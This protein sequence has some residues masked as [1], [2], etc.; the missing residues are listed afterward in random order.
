MDFKKRCLCTN[1]GNS[2]PSIRHKS[3]PIMDYRIFARNELKRHEERM[4]MQRLYVMK[5]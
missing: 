4:I 5:I 2:V 3:V 1:Y